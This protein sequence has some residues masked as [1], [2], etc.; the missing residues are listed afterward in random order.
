MKCTLSKAPFLYSIIKRN[1]CQLKHK[2][3]INDNWIAG[4][5]GRICEKIL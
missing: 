2:C 3:N 5:A 1:K 4:K